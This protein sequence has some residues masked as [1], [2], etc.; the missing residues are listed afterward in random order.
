MMRRQPRTNNSVYALSG[1]LFAELAIVLMLLALG[2]AAFTPPPT[3]VQNCPEPPPGVLL[4]TVEFVLFVE[5][6]GAGADT[7]ARFNR[8]LE[9]VVGPK[10]E[11]GLALLFGVSRDE[12]PLNG[13]LVSQ[14]LKDLV[15]GQPQLSKAADIRSYIGGRDDGG[16]GDVKV[17]LF[18]LTTAG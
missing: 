1:W 17:E 6:G 8:E 12:E 5:P 4:D 15:G 2:S 11:V 9:R 7:I 13:T 16:P 10:R 14:R 3:P 18:L